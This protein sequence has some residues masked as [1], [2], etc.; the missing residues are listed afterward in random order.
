MDSAVQQLQAL[1]EKILAAIPDPW[2]FPGVGKV[3]GFM[4]VGPVMF[5]AE[6]PSTGSFP[7]RADRFLYGLLEKYGM[8]NSHL[9]DIIKSRGQVG[10]PYPDMTLHRRVFDQEI[11]IVRPKL[12]IAFG[13]KVYDLLQFAL[14]GTGI[15]IRQVW[16]YAYTRR[17]R[18]KPEAF[19][20]QIKEVLQSEGLTSRSSRPGT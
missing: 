18:E 5:V 15:R 12:I 3:Q 6:R 20:G 11:E 16:H 17:G 19:E 13:Q 10:A 8:E 1:R 14:A 2:L 4:G 7:S 9:T